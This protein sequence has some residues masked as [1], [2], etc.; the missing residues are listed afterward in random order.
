V[1]KLNGEI[2]GDANRYGSLKIREWLVRR[3]EVVKKG[4]NAAG[5]VLLREGKQ[6]ISG[7]GFTRDPGRTSPYPGILTGQMRRTFTSR[8]VNRGGAPEQHVGPAV[9]YAVFHEV[10]TKNMPARPFMKPLAEIKGDEA[11]DAMIHEILKPL[12]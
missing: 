5:A 6:M 8:Q 11:I 3:P 7:L 1:I 12:D 4:L 2:V 10:G 9:E